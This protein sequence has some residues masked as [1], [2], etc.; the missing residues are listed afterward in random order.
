MRSMVSPVRGSA[1]RAECAEALTIIER[2]WSKNLNKKIKTLKS[3]IY[4]QAKRK[5]AYAIW[6]GKILRELRESYVLPP[7]KLQVAFPGWFI[8]PFKCTLK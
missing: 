3:M 2:K 7:K 1:S 8:R 6:R 5:R 4:Y